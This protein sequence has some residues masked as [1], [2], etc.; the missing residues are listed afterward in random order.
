M[1]A[2]TNERH[3]GGDLQ[4]TG[5]GRG[6][7]S[8]E[9]SREVISSS[10]LSGSPVAFEQQHQRSLNKRSCAST[11]DA[12]AEFGA[13]GMHGAEIYVFC[14]RVHAARNAQASANARS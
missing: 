9:L 4:R 8:Q 14:E 2:R 7:F 10:Q 13:H 12:Q 1:C 5:P 6:M 11:V 3:T